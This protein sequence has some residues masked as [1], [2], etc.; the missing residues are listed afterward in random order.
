VH[1]NNAIIRIL[2]FLPPVKRG[3]YIFCGISLVIVGTIGIFVPLLPTTPFLL[4][5]A[6][7]F[8]KSSDR[9]YYWLLNNKI[10]GKYIRN[11]I[12]KKGVPLKIKI[13]TLILLWFSIAYAFLFVTNNVWVRAALLIVLVGVSMHILLIRTKK[14]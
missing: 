7:C 8:L 9:A 13:F 1:L 11:Y 5:A 10:Y 6:A 3:L 2:V 12:E 14:K 4:L